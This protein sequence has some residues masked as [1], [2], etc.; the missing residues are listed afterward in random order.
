MLLSKK[1]MHKTGNEFRDPTGRP[2]NKQILTFKTVNY[3]LE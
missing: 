2:N 3:S 1:N